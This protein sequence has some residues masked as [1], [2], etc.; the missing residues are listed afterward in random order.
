[1]SLC[2][3][4]TLIASFP[5]LSRFVLSFAFNIHGS[6]RAAKNGEGLGTLITWI[7]VRWNWGGRRGAVPD[8]RYMCNKP[9]SIFFD[10]SSGVLVICKH[11]GS[12]LV[13][14]PSMM[15]SSVLFHVFECRPLPPPFVHLGSTWRHSHGKFKFSRPSLFFATLPLPC[16]IQQKQ[17]RPGNEA[18][19][20]VAH[21]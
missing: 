2:H 6:R 10:W 12:C 14:E 4:H 8:Y 13:T 9:E 18:V 15:K 3:H 21:Y 16:I 5:G 20:T 19:L 11:L 1:M 17:G 7:N